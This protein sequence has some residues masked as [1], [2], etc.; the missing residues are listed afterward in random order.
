M[1]LLSLF[2][3]ATVTTSQPATVSRCQVA[4]TVQGSE[5]AVA[6]ATAPERISLSLKINSVEDKCS[7]DFP[8]DTTVA[9]ILVKNNIKP[10]DNLT[11]GTILD[12]SVA[13]IYKNAAS[14]ESYKIVNDTKQNP[15]TPETES[16]WIRL[17][18]AI[19]KLFGW[20]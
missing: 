10:G 9:F 1:L 8:K 13:Y 7:S 16:F 20:K 3:A 18:N 19:K 11:T 6:P 4:G 5:P 2:L 12:T 15:T 17:I 14:I